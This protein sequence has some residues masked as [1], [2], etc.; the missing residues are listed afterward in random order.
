M[1]KVKC[2]SVFLLRSK[3]YETE[4]VFYFEKTQEIQLTDHSNQHFN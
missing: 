4:A 3:S 1:E 2:I